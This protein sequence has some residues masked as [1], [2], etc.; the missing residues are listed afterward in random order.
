MP[1]IYQRMATARSSAA[2]ISSY[3]QQQQHI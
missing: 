3:Q 2:S 1:R